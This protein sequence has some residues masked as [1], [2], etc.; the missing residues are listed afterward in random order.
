MEES[1]RYL[2]LLGCSER[3]HAKDG[4]VPAIELYD[5]VNYRVLH[6]AKQ[7]GYWPVTLRVLIL[8]AKHALLDPQ[9]LIE[10]YDQFM[11]REQAVSLQQK[12]GAELDAILTQQH[13]DEVCI[14]LGKL[15]LLALATS[16]ELPRLGARAHYATGGVGE[17]MA[18]MKH[19]LIHIAGHQ[20][21]S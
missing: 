2:L 15:Y 18:Q 7:G 9:T 16:Q 20:S 14:N 1:S 3:K 8:S 19:W 11:T 10:Y 13:F 5:G 4:L 21:L 6:K 12:A 17:R